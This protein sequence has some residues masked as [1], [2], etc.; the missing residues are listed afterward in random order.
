MAARSLKPT[1]P[2]KRTTTIRKLGP[3]VPTINTPDAN[4]LAGQMINVR[5]LAPTLPERI[6][7]GWCQRNAVNLGFTWSSQAPEAGS[8]VRDTGSAVVDVVIETPIR[9]FI[10]LQS[11]YWH[12]FAD[13]GKVAHDYLQ[14][15]ALEVWAPVVDVYEEQIFADVDGVM[16]DAL[17]LKERPR[18]NSPL[19]PSRPPG[20]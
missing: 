18:P 3:K 8:F 10:R 7:Y 12:I 4:L 15:L 17:N 9:I 2:T 5:G 1:L 6:L 13:A 20:L 11:N 16:R 19:T 14:R